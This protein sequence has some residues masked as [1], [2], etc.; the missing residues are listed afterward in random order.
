MIH[1]LKLAGSRLY[2]AHRSR[3]CFLAF[4]VLVLAGLPSRSFAQNATIVGTVTDPSGSVIPNVSVTVTNVDTGRTITFPTN[5]DGQYV[6][7][8]LPV[9]HYNVKAT[10]EGFRA[11]ER[12]G[13]VLNVGDRLR[14]DF[15]MA[16]GAKTETISVEANAIQVQSD[17]S[18]VSSLV[19]AK[20][21][22]ELATNGRTIYSYVALTPGASSLTP[23]TQIPIPTGGA[24]DQVDIESFKQVLSSGNQSPLL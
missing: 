23:D 18:E 14:V 8:D 12:G 13:I 20:Q 16:V 5:E 1:A 9:G 15:R 21:I 22:S 3:L 17:S 19:N 10:A 4:L 6:V 2:S 11:A 7:P 24:S